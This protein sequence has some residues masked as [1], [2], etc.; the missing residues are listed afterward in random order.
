MK[1]GKRISINNF[2]SR[3]SSATYMNY[4]HIY[5]HAKNNYILEMKVP[6]EFYDRYRRQ[7]RSNIGPRVMYE[8]W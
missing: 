8:N 6:N 2:R 5:D 4:F 7:I 3:F 1:I